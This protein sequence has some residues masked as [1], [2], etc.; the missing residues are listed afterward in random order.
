ML[1]RLAARGDSWG[2]FIGLLANFR[3]DEEERKA[4]EKKRN[5]KPIMPP[6]GLLRQIQKEK[7]KAK[8]NAEQQG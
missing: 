4:R 2:E 3:L 1:E 5:M 6:P 7:A 8:P